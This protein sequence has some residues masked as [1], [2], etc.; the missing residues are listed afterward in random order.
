MVG[1]RME[2][3][4]RSRRVEC[5]RRPSVCGLLDRMRLVLGVLWLVMCVRVWLSAV[6]PTGA[7]AEVLMGGP[8]CSTTSV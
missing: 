8:R 2:P 1:C 6:C 3:G 5:G 4:R 7:E